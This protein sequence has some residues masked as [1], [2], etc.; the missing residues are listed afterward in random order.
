MTA[1]L[2][3]DSFVF[4]GLKTHTQLAEARSYLLN[5][6]GHIRPYRDFQE[7]VSKLNKRYNKNYLE[8][9]YEYA[10]QSAQ[11]IEAWEN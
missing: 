7:K 1:Y 2:Q 11:S 4:S 3:Q 6:Q 9:E 8:A 5:E 10:I